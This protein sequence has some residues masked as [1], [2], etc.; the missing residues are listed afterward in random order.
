MRRTSGGDGGGA[1]DGGGGSAGKKRKVSDERC[2]R[3][4]ASSAGLCANDLCALAFSSLPRPHD[5]GASSASASTSYPMRTDYAHPPAP[6]ASLYASAPSAAAGP[7]SLG[8]SILPPPPAHQQMQHQPAYAAFLPAGAPAHYGGQ[9]QPPQ[10]QQ[11]SSFGFGAEPLGMSHP[12]PTA[13]LQQQRAAPYLPPPHQ[14]LAPSSAPYGAHALH[15]QPQSHYRPSGSASAPPPPPPS[16]SP[17][18]HASSPTAPLPAF[19][20]PMPSLLAYLFSPTEVRSPEHG[21]TDQTVVG[22]DG[23][24]RELFAREPSQAH[25]GLLVEALRR[26]LAAD[27]IESYFQVRLR[28]LPIGCTCPNARQPGD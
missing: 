12:L 26:E 22:H 3:Q 19:P 21:Y 14:Q 16:L 5:L 11:Q 10:Q 4:L 20:P 8:P 18:A 25:R 23:G 24:K 17:L 6:A 28:P 15:A 1:D 27:L 9:Q 2:V 7:S 13:A